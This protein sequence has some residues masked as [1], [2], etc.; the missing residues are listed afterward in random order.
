MSK[1][2]PSRKQYLDFKKQFPDA[3]VMFRLGDFYEM[4]DHDAEVAA[5]E[6]DLVLTGRPVAKGERVPM[7]GVPHH[8]VEGYIARLVEKGFHVAVIEQ[9]GNEPVNGLTPREV[10]RVITP[11][12]V[13]EPGMLSDDRHSYLMA[14]APEPD[15]SGASW[16]A[17]GLA[18][19]DISTGEFAATELTGEGATLGVVEELVRLEPREV[20]LPARWAERGVRLPESAHVTPLPDYRFEQSFARQALLDHFAIAT[21]DGFGVQDKPLAVRAAGAILVYLQETQRSTLG[22]LMTLHS[23][24]TAG[25]MTLDAATRRNLELTET[26]REGRKRGSLLDVLDRTVTPMGGRLLRTWI[27]QPLLDRAALEA[28]L[29]AVEALHGSATARASVRAA[30]KQVSDLERLTNRLLLGR[31]GPRE[32]LALAEGLGAVPDLRETISSAP[33][34]DALHDALDPCEDVRALVAQA[35]ADDPPATLNTTGVIRPGF[36]AEL[37]QVV[38]ATRGARE[39]VAGLEEVERER[40]GI[41]SLKVGY[42]KVFGYYIEVSRANAERVPDDYI[43]KQTLV[44]AERYITPELKEYEA[45]ILNAEEQLLEIEGRLFREVCE[46]IAQRAAALLETAR[47]IA[48]LDVFASLA[49]VAAREN[50]VRPAL[51]GEDALT[52]RDGRHPVVERMLAGERFV[53][54]DTHFDAHERLHIITGPNMAGKSTII[55]QVALI[56]LMAQIGSFV[57]AREASI[58]LADRIFTRI[59]AQDEI[60]AGQSTFM[61]E[62]VELALILAHATRR[63]LLILDEIGRGTSTYDGMAIARAVVEY[64][65]NNPRLGSR[66]LFATHYHELTELANILPGVANYNVAVAEEGDEVVFL[67]RLMPG[68]ANRSYGIHV[69]QLAGIPKAVINRANEILEELEGAGSDF[70]VERRA[71]PAGSVQLSFFQTDP[72]PVVKA[73]KALKIDEMTPLDALTK[74][75]ELKRLVDED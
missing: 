60:H 59:G 7:C 75:Y 54:N 74:L 47:A 67:H 68:G 57:P 52:I 38:A 26:I 2:T 53:P 48:H 33:A 20:L 18:F 58:G 24:S 29:D 21:L 45:L 6:L 35:L 62:M 23:Y 14:L 40:T 16:A 56:V 12:T 13:I 49:E 39:W 1:L 70:R 19:V 44:N 17:V 30:L 50:Y 41:K 64:L 27:G 25:F 72:D 10:S 22:H 63:S 61:V 5:R 31:A 73:V 69:A 28:R 8:A 32:L 66:T 55:R 9:V 42:N 15:A 37:D 34:L 71:K 36:S 43:R 46:R 4:F 65:H 3:I 51:T 11:G